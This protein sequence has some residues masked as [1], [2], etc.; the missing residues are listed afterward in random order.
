MSGDLEAP[1]RHI[2]MENVRSILGQN[3]AKYGAEE[4][5]ESARRQSPRGF[6]GIAELWGASDRGGGSM[7]HL[8]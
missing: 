6:P 2:Y 1:C 7:Q 4:G 5:E 3:R 8:R